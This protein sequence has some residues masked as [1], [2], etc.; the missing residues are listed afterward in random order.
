MRNP[1]MRY[2]T[3]LQNAKAIRSHIQELYGDY[4]RSKNPIVL[5]FIQEWTKKYKEKLVKEQEYLKLNTI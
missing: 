5:D 1:R 4:N 2:H 3:D